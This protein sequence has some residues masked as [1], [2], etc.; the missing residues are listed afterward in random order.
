MGFFSLISRPNVFRLVIG[1]IGGMRGYESDGAEGGCSGVDWSISPIIV[2]EFV[3]E[4]INA[5]RRGRF[6]AAAIKEGKHFDASMTTEDSDELSRRSS[7]C[8]WSL[9]GDLHTTFELT[10]CVGLRDLSPSELMN[11][12]VLTVILCFRVMPD[13]HLV[14]NSGVLLSTSFTPTV[15][16]KQL[17]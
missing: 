12:Y 16:V 13:P 7:R 6:V 10:R 3:S 4:E 11:I 9:L 2:V 5:E 15:H 1:L 8:L 17:Q 14:H